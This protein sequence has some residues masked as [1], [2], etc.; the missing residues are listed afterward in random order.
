[1][2]T[3]FLEPEICQG[4]TTR[5]LD[6]NWTRQVRSLLYHTYR[7]DPIFRHILEADR[8]GY[9]QR[10]RAC[11]REL[12]TLYFAENMPVIGLLDEERLVGVAFVCSSEKAE[13]LLTRLFWR[14]KMIMTIGYRCTENYLT[15]IQ[16]LHDT[17]PESHSY[18]LPMVGVHPELRERGYGRRLL[19]AV[20][21]LCDLDQTASGCTVAL[22]E[23]NLLPFFSGLGYIRAAIIEEGDHTQAMLFRERPQ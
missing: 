11:T 21:D 17:L 23:G 15:Y 4:I 16:Q 3:L 10:I 1:M 12:A 22:S 2:T 8:K 20:H 9:E 14:V 5:Y 6:T 7:H 18:L 13:E 19:E